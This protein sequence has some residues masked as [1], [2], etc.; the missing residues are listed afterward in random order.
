VPTSFWAP[1]RE[2]ADAHGLPI[3]AIES[4]T[5]AWRA[6]KGLWRSDSLP[7]NVDSVWW[8]VGGQLGLVFLSDA[9]YVPA[10][11]TLIST[12]DGDGVGF[13]KLLWELRALRQMPLASRGRRLGQILEQLGEVEGEGL[14]RTVHADDPDGLIEALRR[15]GVRVGQTDEGALRFCPSLD[16]TDLEL[17][18]LEAAITEV[19]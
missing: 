18:R 19:A 3:V 10:K 2:L 1:L 13:H 12:W 9:L 16:I 14:Y 11:L 7:V 4:A 8:Y 15:R 5:A 17:D 6:G